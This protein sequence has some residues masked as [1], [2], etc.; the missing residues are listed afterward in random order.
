MNVVHLQLSGGIGGI[1]VLTRDIA[2][3]SNNNNIFYFLFEGGEIADRL[4][5]EGSSVQVENDKNTGFIK[6]AKKFVDFCKRNKADVII[7]HT[8]SPVL[9]FIFAY[10]KRHYKNAVYLLY[11]HSNARYGS[12]ENKLK[13][14]ASRELLMEAYRASKYAV[15][16]S[17][18]VKESFIEKYGFKSE[19]CKVV[20]NGIDLNKF[21]SNRLT[22]DYGTFNIIY[23]GR[24]LPEKG[25]HILID[26]LSML[27][28]DCKIKLFIVGR[29]YNG[30]DNELTAQAKRLG[31]EDKI[32]LTG[33]SL[34]V[35]KY[36]AQADLFVHPAVSE[37]GFGIALAEAMAAYVPCVAFNEGAMP[38]IIDNG[39]NG[40]IAKEMTAASL[41][42]E[43]G[44]AYN[45]FIEGKYN[46]IRE[47]AHQKAQAFSIEAMVESLENLY[48]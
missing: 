4:K 31:L 1:S 13:R 26:A 21:Y 43:I 12:Y 24:V 42:Q 10:C 15:A 6:A 28:G 11:L 25:V 20:Y 30:Y 7:C 2:L 17:K 37:E 46:R 34:D 38:E 19:K 35:P 39:I 3:K 32:Q 16:I 40:F 8:G 23:V 41:S 47:S 29:A 14:F 22:D 9:R 33:P 36:L 48:C 27:P 5:A 18:S 45:L 44:K